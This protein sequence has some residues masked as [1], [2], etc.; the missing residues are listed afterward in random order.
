MQ[1]SFTKIYQNLA[2]KTNLTF[3]KNQILQNKFSKQNDI[4]LKI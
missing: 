3:K 1:R 2:N 4:K